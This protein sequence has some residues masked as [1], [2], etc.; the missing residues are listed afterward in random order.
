MTP[1]EHI[2]DDQLELGVAVR[3][4][5]D[6]RWRALLAVLRGAVGSLGTKQGLDLAE[7]C[8]AD[9]GQFSRALH[10]KANFSLRWLIVVLWRDRS[11][12]V[13]GFLCRLCGGE[14]V[15]KPR[16]TDAQKLERLERTLRAKAGAVGEDLIRDAYGEDVALEG[17]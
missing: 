15:E 14:F 9:P 6:D 5:L 11:R 13:I 1:P 8:D 12:S 7:E 2:A 4:A 10:G 3:S 17:R 16:F